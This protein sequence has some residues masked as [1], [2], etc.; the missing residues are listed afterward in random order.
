MDGDG[1]QVP[2]YASSQVH[3][4]WVDSCVPVGLQGPR[5]WRVCAVVSGADVGEDQSQES[6]YS[7]SVGA[8]QKYPCARRRPVKPVSGPGGAIAS[9]EVARVALS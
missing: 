5:W 3:A 2:E 6:T 1:L 8:R 7:P 9:T 4:G